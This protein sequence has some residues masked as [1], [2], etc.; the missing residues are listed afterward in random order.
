MRNIIIYYSRTGKTKL[1]AETISQEIDAQLI[2]I[3]DKTN[4]SGSIGF[5]KGAL[6]TITNND[7]Q[8]EPN[9][10][11]LTPYDNIY[12]GTPVW[13]SKVAPAIT[14]IIKN[15]KLENKNVITFATLNKHGAETTL[16][17]LND[18]IKEKN[19]KIIKSFAIITK[20]T[21]IEKLTKQAIKDM[22]D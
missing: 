8:I 19:G 9:T 3:K 12:I 1:V 11:D 14:E 10:I 4:R 6:D 18:A 2:E 16:N 20:N 5:V 21:D 22:E 13:A 17:I 15:L 7:T